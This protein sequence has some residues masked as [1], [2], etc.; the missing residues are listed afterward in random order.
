MYTHKSLMKA[1]REGT[2]LYPNS[3]E[4]E[5]EESKSEAN[6]NYTVRACL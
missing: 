6:L 3:R 2:C 5:A 1:R 4:A